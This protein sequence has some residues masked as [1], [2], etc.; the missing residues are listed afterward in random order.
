MMIDDDDTKS[1]ENLAPR[2]TE[3]KSSQILVM[4]SWVSVLSKSDKFALQMYQKYLC[5]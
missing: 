4:D 2:V 1:L 3:I 5:L